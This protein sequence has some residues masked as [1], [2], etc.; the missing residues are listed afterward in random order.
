M[1]RRRAGPGY[2]FGVVM[3]RMSTELG[4]VLGGRYRIIAPIGMGAS[5]Q[6]F[7]ADDVR[8]RRRVA[9]KMLHAALA[10]D[11]E[12][13][14][15]FHAEAQA[16]AALNHP[17]ILSVF[18]WGDD[19]Q[20]PFLVTE[21]LA[22]GSLRAVLDQGNLL[23]PAQALRVGLE[24]SRAL[25]YAHGRGLVH[26]D[27]KPAN[28]LFG[29]EG[30]L[31]VADFGLARALAEAAWTEPQGAVL[32]TARYASP[33][34]AQGETLTT[35]SDV[36][37]LALVLVEAVTGQVPFSADTTIGTLMARV[38]KPLQVPDALGPLA[39]ALARAA[40]ADPAERLD[41]HGLGVALMAV[42]R[43]LDRPERLPLAGALASAP[44]AAGD[45]D[46]T[47]SPPSRFDPDVAVVPVVVAEPSA[48]GQE[49]EAPDGDVAALA[50][51][52]P[53]WAEPADGPPTESVEPAVADAGATEGDDGAGPQP[54]ASA[55]GAAPAD[56][57]DGADQPDEMADGAA[58][59]GLAGGAEQ[60]GEVADGAASA[61]MADADQPDADQAPA[62]DAEQAPAGDLDPP[63]VPIEPETAAA[64]V[65]LVP[66]PPSP[67][68]GGP[69]RYAQSDEPDGPYDEEA[70]YDYDDYEDQP[71]RRGWIVLLVMLVLLA[72]AVMGGL[73]L[74]G[75]S[76]EGVKRVPSLTGLQ[77]ATA[78][79][80]V[81]PFGWKLIEEH[82][83]KDGT[84][85]GQVLLTDPGVGTRL[86]RGDKIRFTV[87]D[88][89][90]LVDVPGGV[91]GQPQSAVETLY[92]A[93][94]LKVAAT[95]QFDED[96]AQGSLIDLVPGT[97]P[98]LTR[99]S[100][101]AVLVS[102]GPM[103]RVIPEGLAGLGYDDAAAKL[104]DL[105]LNP[106]RADQYNDDK[107]I[108]AGQI[109]DTDPKADATVPRDSN[110]TLFVSAG[111]TP[112]AVP[113]TER[114]PQAQAVAALGN[115]GFF[116]TVVQDFSDTI[117][118][119]QAVGTR[120][121]AGSTA[122]PGTTIV[123]VVSK[124]Q[125]LV[126]VPPVLGTNTAQ[127]ASLRLTVA[128]LTPGTVSGKATGKPVATAPAV[129]SPVKRGTVVNIVLS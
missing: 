100:T 113:P 31:R 43:Q 78:K 7:L 122:Q 25:D 37:S 33:E 83:R 45:D 20:Q 98:Q 81:A 90:T 73:A 49:P 125:D 48:A 111:P 107:N 50:G 39:P 26:R 77:L 15:R 117:P 57:A 115:V 127:E 129:G 101:V 8:L 68:D 5:A 27:I 55:F 106:V 108:K 70:E 71:R 97:P 116:V 54:V 16:A 30:R 95:P 120:P 61:E 103:P 4:R 60:S 102:N 46:P 12:F 13:L 96:V 40:L 128:G 84:K 59:A 88:G 11:A 29:D 99:G 114:Q 74:V 67:G 10:D 94:G 66:A 53:E 86:R 105:R 1:H 51:P 32:G 2:L 91:R 121:A 56:L 41:A 6:V 62:G 75:A 79:H 65:A 42:A 21:F 64:P 82:T 85:P 76:E 44:I 58:A 23:T 92:G 38:N 69:D 18:D 93:V 126:V 3:S 124:G 89:P 104:T 34:Q 63:T 72:G 109:F 112:V 87:S 36:Y 19:G 123:L 9:V 118:A 24:A 80:R 14:R 22:G 110:V 52:E 28:L 17:H 47:L 35:K 119:G